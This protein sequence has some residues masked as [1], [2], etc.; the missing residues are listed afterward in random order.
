MLRLLWTTWVSSGPRNGNCK[1]SS[2]FPFIQAELFSSLIYSIYRKKQPRTHF[3]NSPSLYV[4]SDAE[5]PLTSHPAVLT[6]SSGTFYVMR[7][8]HEGRQ[9]EGKMLRFCVSWKLIFIFLQNCVF[10]TTTNGTHTHT[11]THIYMYIQ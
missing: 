8:K 9:G 6:F 1:F 5:L 4:T 7:R 10:N 11:H 2:E 3:Q